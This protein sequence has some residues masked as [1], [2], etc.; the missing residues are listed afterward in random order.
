[1]YALFQ[2]NLQ[3]RLFANFLDLPN[4]S[5]IRYS[6]Q[7]SK[8]ISVHIPYQWGSYPTLYV[9]QYTLQEI[10]VASLIPRLALPSC[11]I[12]RLA[13]PSCL[14]PRLALPSCLIPRLALPSCLIPR[15]GLSSPVLSHSKATY[16]VALLKCLAFCLSMAL[17]ASQAIKMANLHSIPP[18]AK[19]SSK[20]P[21]VVL[22]FKEPMGTYTKICTM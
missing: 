21:P 8:S 16:T 6:V 7:S 3:K 9:R 19:H 5:T 17:V 22:F 11:L 20:T 12:P 15:Q 2:R 1:M 18:W 14:I 4:L 13:L 10:A